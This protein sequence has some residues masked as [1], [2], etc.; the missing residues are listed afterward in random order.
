VQGYNHG[1]S[2]RWTVI[3]VVV[4]VA[5]V[6]VFAILAAKAV[7]GED[8]Q[9]P[10]GQPA[11]T[12]QIGRLVKRL[13]DSGLLW[14]GVGYAVPDGEGRSDLLQAGVVVGHIWA[15]VGQGKPVVVSLS[16]GV[17]EAK[18]APPQE[19]VRRGVAK[20]F[21]GE[22]VFGDVTDSFD[23]PDVA[24]VWRITRKGD[25]MVIQGWSL[26][27]GGQLLGLVIKKVEG[28]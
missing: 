23:H 11:S 16:V 8:S 27:E 25:G 13:H 3:V 14:H 26:V 4:I 20:F 12:E 15:M 18:L 24:K 22:W 28:G 17:R 5:V 6:V 19:N 21:R 1:V 2:S 9:S 10:W 7:W